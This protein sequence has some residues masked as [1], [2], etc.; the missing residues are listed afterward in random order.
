MRC[1]ATAQDARNA[2]PADRMNPQ[3][4]SCLRESMSLAAHALGSVERIAS[5]AGRIDE[6]AAFEARLLVLRC[7]LSAG[8][9]GARLLAEIRTFV[10]EF[11]GF[12]VECWN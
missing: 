10:L 11:E 3:T 12:V 6:L 4:L 7:R 9:K 2:N 8:D 5:L 1:Q